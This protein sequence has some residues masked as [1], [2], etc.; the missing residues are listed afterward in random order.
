MERNGYNKIVRLMYGE[1]VKYILR[2]ANAEEM[3]IQKLKFDLITEF[4]RILSD[5]ADI[6]EYF[7]NGI[8][9]NVFI[10]NLIARLK[11]ED[12]WELWNQIKK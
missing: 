6:D 9:K 4:L 5:Y 8:T 3:E 11:P 10:T 12:L 7:G 1:S 2:Q